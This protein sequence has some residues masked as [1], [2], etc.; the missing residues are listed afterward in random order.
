MAPEGPASQSSR[1]HHQ[2]AVAAAAASAADPPDPGH[3]VFSGVPID[4]G[5]TLIFAIIPAS[6]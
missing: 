1:P 5:T 6:S 3:F 2:L 4:A